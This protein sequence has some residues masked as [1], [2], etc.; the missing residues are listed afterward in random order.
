MT[1]MTAR[2]C[3][4]PTARSRQTGSRFHYPAAARGSRRWRRLRAR[5]RGLWSKLRTRTRM[6]LHTMAN[7]ILAQHPDVQRFEIGDWK[8]QETLADTGITFVNKRINRAVQNNHPLK[9]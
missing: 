6:Y 9:H 1:V 7:Q 4:S 5:I 2:S 8:K 3:A